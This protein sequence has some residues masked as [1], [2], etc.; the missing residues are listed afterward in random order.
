MKFLKNVAIYDNSEEDFNILDDI[1]SG[2]ENLKNFAYKA[3]E[4]KQGISANRAF[5]GC[6]E[7]VSIN[8]SA[9][10]YINSSEEMCS[11]CSNLEFLSTTYPLKINLGKKTFYKCTKLSLEVG[12]KYKKPNLLI[13]TP[14]IYGL[15]DELS[16][17]NFNYNSTF[18]GCKEIKKLKLTIINDYNIDKK[19]G[20]VDFN[21]FTRDSCIQEVEIHCDSDEFFFQSDI[22]NAEYMFGDNVKNLSLF[23]DN[24]KKTAEVDKNVINKFD[25]FK[26]PDN[27]VRK[28][29]RKTK[30]SENNQNINLTNN[31][32]CKCCKCFK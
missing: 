27:F 14:Y 23:K 13:S 15:G 29:A 10:S 7:L 16:T 8:F 12:H 25:F 30:N 11:G 1:C 6:K 28:F 32:C 24:I 17:K 20:F 4:K 21:N 19:G 2:C 31:G 9:C 18:D 22:K 26:D 5:K 3:S